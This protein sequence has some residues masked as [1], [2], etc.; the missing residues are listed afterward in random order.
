MPDRKYDGIVLAV[1][2]S[3]FLEFDLDKL[4]NDNTIIFD[5]KSFIPDIGD[6]K[7]YRL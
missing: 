5:I 3:D 4:S 1:S 6:R 2:H 7:I